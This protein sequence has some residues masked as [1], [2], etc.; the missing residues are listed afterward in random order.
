MMN[1]PPRVG[2][3]VVLQ[4]PFRVDIDSRVSTSVMT[5]SAELSSLVI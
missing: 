5:S 1:M 2:F 3:V 4:L